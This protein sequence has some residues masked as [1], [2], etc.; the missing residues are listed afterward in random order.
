M[1]HGTVDLGLLRRHRDFRLLF[2]GQSVTA[3]GSAITYVAVPYQAYQ[4]TGSSLVVGLIGLAEFVP[5][6]LAS[7]VGGALADARDRR[8]M[9][10]LTE[11]GLA[12]SSALLLANALVPEPRLL[13]LFVAAGTT[14]ALDGLQRPSLEAMT[15]RLVRREELPAAVALGSLRM[16]LAS[17]LGPAAAGGL[18]AGVGLPVTYG[19]DVLTFLLSLAALAAMRPVPAPDDAPRPSL[20][21]VLDG[22]RYARSRP[23]LLG[24][25]AVDFMAMFFGMPRALFPAMADDLGG[26]GVLGLLHSAPAAGAVLIAATSGWTARIHRHGLAVIVAALGWGVAIIVL[27]FSDG[28]V[29]ALLALAVA[30]GADQISAIFRQTMWAATVPDHLR[31]RLAGLEMVSYTSGPLLGNVESGVAAAL[32]GVRG[33]VISGGVLCVVGV[34]LVAVAVPALRRYDTRRPLPDGSGAP[35]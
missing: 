26:P 28:L 20:R 35:R 21:S 3:I 9:V 23:D 18:I 30:G 11:L 10:Q 25:Y 5:L 7:F 15:P 13:V 16:N 1:R 4:I 22:V 27:G 2:V 17:V 8:R 32:L 24:T 31:G 12:A 6:L 14:A 33:A 34:G 29:L 19:L